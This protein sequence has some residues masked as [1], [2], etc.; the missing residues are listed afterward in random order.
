M[1]EEG[2]TQSGGVEIA[3]GVRVPEASLRFKAT[4]SSGPGGQNVN[5]VATRMELRLALSEIPLAKSAMAR[6][7]RHER[8]RITSEGELI[9][10]NEESRS[11]HRNRG[12]CLELLREMLVRAM[13]EPK[14]RIATRPS[15]GSVERRLEA[16]SRR[17]ALK[18][19]RR[20]PDS[21]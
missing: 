11:Q 2:G 16:K 18:R 21:E 17:S 5:K 1:T 13:A 15:R 10:A 8:G 4:R 20:P 12:R 19:R 14:R 6:L 3:P 9:I 7:R